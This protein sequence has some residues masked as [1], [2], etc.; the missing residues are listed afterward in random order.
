MA[1]EVKDWKVYEKYRNECNELGISEY[2]LNIE[3]LQKYR[4]SY[5]PF[6]FY[7]TA[8]EFLVAKDLKKE[9]DNKGRFILQSKIR[10]SIVDSLTEKII[11][12]LEHEK[13]GTR[14]SIPL[15]SWTC[16]HAYLFKDNSD[17]LSPM[18]IHLEDDWDVPKI[19]PILFIY[20][21]HG[22]IKQFKKLSPYFTTIKKKRSVL[23]KELKGKDLIW[24][25]IDDI[26]WTVT[27][28]DPI[29]KT[30]EEYYWEELKNES[31]YHESVTEYLKFKEND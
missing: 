1:F 5:F 30:K 10:D 20:L 9:K 25:K 13:K 24:D 26:T 14:W 27:V 28:K 22:Y 17:P 31:G 19:T 18:T 2:G 6:D 15:S 29:R 23:P 7:L 16:F 3:L 21:R 12:I 11:I 8:I 4:E